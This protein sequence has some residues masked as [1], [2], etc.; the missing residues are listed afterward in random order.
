MAG[1]TSLDVLGRGHRRDPRRQVT[2]V[3][4]LLDRIGDKYEILERIKLGGMGA[5]YRVRH[6][7]LDEV[8][9]VKVM[10]PHLVGDR[11]EEDGFLRE[12][13]LSSRLRHPN[14]AQ[15][16]DAIIDQ[17]G[18]CQIVME[19]VSGLDLAELLA[20]IGPPDLDL[21]LEVA[22]QALAALAYL[23]RRQLVHRDVSPDNFVL[24]RGDDGG[25]AVKMVDLG[26]ARARG[27]SDGFGGGSDFVGKVPYAAPERLVRGSDDRLDE[28]SDLFSFG[29]VLYELLTGRR[30][31]AGTDPAVV[32]A[33]HL[34]PPLPFADSDPAELV[35]A[36]LRAVVL[37]ALARQPRIR[38]E[39]ADA[40]VAAL[41]PVRRR[42][43]LAADAMSRL[44]RRL[45]DTAAN[46]AGT[47]AVQVTTIKVPATA[48]P[49]APAS[50]ER[51]AAAVALVEEAREHLRHE[52][53]AA[54]IASLEQAV[55]AA[56]DLSA[57]RDL[58]ATTRA[59]HEQHRRLHDPNAAAARAADV[60][61]LCL[62][63]GQLAAAEA[64]I[65]AARKRFGA[66]SAVAALAARAAALAAQRQR[67]RTLV[68]EAAARIK[69]GSLTRARAL[70]DQ[71]LAADP[72]DEAA[73]ALKTIT[74]LA[75]GKERAIALELDELPRAVAEISGLLEV[76]EIATAERLL[77]VALKTFGRRDPLVELE[78]TLVAHRQRE[79]GAFIASHLAAARRALADGDYREALA[80]LRQA[81]ALAPSDPEV[82]GL[83]DETVRRHAAATIE[84]YVAAGELA[85]AER[86][87]SV[88]T[89]LHGADPRFSRLR[90][91]LEQAERGGAAAALTSL[92]VNARACL[93]R[94][95][96]ATCLQELRRA[97]KLD[98]GSDQIRALTAEAMRRHAE[99]TI[100]DY[101]AH[102]QVAE[103]ERALTVACRLHGSDGRLGELRLDLVRLENGET[104]AAVATLLASAR[105]MIEDLDDHAALR[106]LRRV[107][108]LDPGNPPGG[109]QPREARRPP[110]LAANAAHRQSG[111]APDPR[112]AVDLATK[113]FGDH[114]TLQALRE[115]VEDLLALES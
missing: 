35:P 4:N 107:G 36:D 53:F 3:T 68:A 37:T 88:A 13:K 45:D 19:H 24:S 96:F 65:D 21:T 59:A 2:T 15:S 22:R 38:F 51:S 81:G 62:D 55:A 56:P 98:P 63:T 44:Q 48:L 92:L 5:V 31:F 16:Y 70:L 1:Y 112:P 95:D 114:V 14:L 77:G 74:E 80:E 6:R 85:E 49:A 79:R 104:A 50:P 32:A 23:H 111:L 29:V 113:L 66:S 105:R 60:I 41:D 73:A 90:E 82:R 42:V 10:R 64:R 103:A 9:V 108:E 78:R 102:G 83:L 69:E 99:L 71:A 75:I 46:P 27:R 30:P 39:S 47:T 12:A 28:R 67:A 89:K 91:A 100:A 40:F 61:G 58:L 20:R 97:G 18:Y 54:T 106:T 33:A 7:L 109:S 34:A 11:D 52:R 76:A 72:M 87:L 25:P 57:A 110:V 8:R 115:R 84:S 86:A 94:D 17:E 101:L 43:P 26:L 93:E